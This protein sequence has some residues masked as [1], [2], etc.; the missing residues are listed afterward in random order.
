MHFD[1]EASSQKDLS[2]KDKAQLCRELSHLLQMSNSSDSSL[3]F[4]EKRK[5]VSY[6]SSRRFASSTAEQLSCFLLENTVYLVN[7]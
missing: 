7:P 4:T 3:S 6:L 2:T 5:K 1:G